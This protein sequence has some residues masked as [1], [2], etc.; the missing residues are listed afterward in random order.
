VIL[1]D[2][3]QAKNFC[4]QLVVLKPWSDEE[5]S[6]RFKNKA[7]KKLPHK[8]SKQ[9]SI[10]TSIVTKEGI[11]I[12]SIAASKEF[13]QEQMQELSKY[14]EDVKTVNIATIEALGKGLKSIIAPLY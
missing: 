11:L 1:I 4:T 6:P 9:I 10:A 3:H 2:F 14:Y 7:P 12:M 5:L 8:L 13:T